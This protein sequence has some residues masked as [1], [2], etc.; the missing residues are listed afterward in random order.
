MMPPVPA[1]AEKALALGKTAKRPPNRNCCSPYR[2]ADTRGGKNPEKSGKKFDPVLLKWFINMAGVYP[3][4]TL[5][6]LNSG[7][8]GLIYKNGAF[9]EQ[10][11]P[12]VL[13]L[14]K[15]GGNEPAPDRILDLNATDKKTG[16][17]LRR[18]KST[19]NPYEY[20]IQPAV[21]LMQA[22]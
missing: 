4:G 5:V 3:V 16:K 17:Y 21:Y 13:L 19:H 18:I 14:R 22:E 6:R 9:A 8:I 2:N 1:V 20:G 15:E 7:E 12:L 10:C 11:M